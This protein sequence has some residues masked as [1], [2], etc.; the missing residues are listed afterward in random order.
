VLTMLAYVRYVE[1][2]R[3]VRYALLLISFTWA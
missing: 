2:P 3:P 1:Q